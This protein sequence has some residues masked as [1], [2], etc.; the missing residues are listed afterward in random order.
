MTNSTNVTNFVDVLRARA[1]E[2]PNRRALTFLADGEIE[3]ATLS[4]AQLD[5]RARAIGAQLETLGARGQC[6]L[7]LFGSGLDYVAAFFGCLYAGAMAVPLYP[8]RPHRADARL[9]AIIEDCAPRFALVGETIA[10]RLTPQEWQQW[11]GVQW[12]AP[13]TTGA[14][15]WRPPTIGADEIAFLQYTSGSLAR[16]KGVMVSHA[17]LVSHHAMLR[18]AFEQTEDSTYVSWLPLFHDMGLIGNLLQGIVGG[19]HVVLMPPE[20]FGIK[21]MRWLR[22]V[23]KYRAQISGGP[24]IAYDLCVQ[25]STPA[26]RESLDLSDWELAFCGAEPVRAATLERFARAFAPHGFARAALY[27]CYGL[28]EATL[29]TS[30]GAKSAAPVIEEFAA[31]ELE[32]G[33]AVRA[34][35]N[36]SQ[37][38]SQDAPQKRALVSCGHA[39]T[40]GEILIA[41]AQTRR[42]CVPGVVGEIWLGGP[43]VARGYWNSPEQSDATF[44]AHT[45]AGDGPYLRTGDLGF[46]HEGELFITGRLKDLIIIAGRNHAP[47]DIEATVVNAHPALRAGR[48][49]A[50]GIDVENSEALAVVAEVAR[51]TPAEA[52]P[53]IVTAIVRAAS[54]HHGL[55]AHVQLIRAAS[56][57]MTSSGKVQ[58]LLTRERWLAD[59]LLPFDAAG[60]TMNSGL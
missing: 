8:P 30:G 47:D 42:V 14:A 19:G 48:A 49:A 25:R 45:D 3:T 22:A 58:R 5:E 37:D 16:P 6:V 26:D 60:E 21:P 2:H 56:L 50:F 23:S 27:P 36:A 55:R 13:A 43:H 1:G 4:Y 51:A 38:A 59:T 11:P 52:A 31:N 10:A 57:P 24:N 44:H 34:S 41:D 20:A 39:W 9:A 17:N 54:A 12:L 40:E 35:Q 29:F 15:N 53:A 18:A 7:L 32:Q 46:F 33:R 28:A